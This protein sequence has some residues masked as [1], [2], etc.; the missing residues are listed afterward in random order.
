MQRNCSTWASRW[1]GNADRWTAREVLCP[2]CPRLLQMPVSHFAAFH[3]MWCL[4]WSE[5]GEG[6]LAPPTPEDVLPGK[7]T[8]PEGMLPV[9]GGL[10][11]PDRPDSSHRTELRPTVPP[12]HLM[13]RHYPHQTMAAQRGTSAANPGGWAPCFTFLFGKISNLL[14]VQGVERTPFGHPITESQDVSPC[15]YLPKVVNWGSDCYSGPV[16][17]T[18]CSHL[19]S[20]DGQWWVRGHACPFLHIVSRSVKNK[21]VSN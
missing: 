8:G 15:I 9:T 4:V 11:Q 16:L 18:A 21:A 20:S 19:P 10:D 1:P 12:S 6:D 5:H 7:H 2:L 3:E 17:E 14:L 13:P